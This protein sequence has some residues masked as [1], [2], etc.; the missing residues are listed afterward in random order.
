MYICA[1]TLRL[2]R[3][4]PNPNRAPCFC[5]CPPVTVTPQFLYI[6]ASWAAAAFGR[7]RFDLLGRGLSSPAASQQ[8][9]NQLRA[10]LAPS[11]G[12]SAAES[13]R[14]SVCFF[15]TALNR[16]AWG[17][18]TIP[19][20]TTVAST[21]T[22]EDAM[23]DFVFKLTQ[24][25][26]GLSG[27]G[28]SG[29]SGSSGGWSGARAENEQGEGLCFAHCSHRANKEQDDALRLA[30]VVGCKHVCREYLAVLERGSGSGDL[31]LQQCG[32]AAGAPGMVQAPNTAAQPPP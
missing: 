21:W 4:S 12:A 14:Y 10:V 31:Q 30:A 8:G 13:A 11:G 24:Q 29:S 28:S 16:T 20:A 5:T 17:G 25:L 1:P 7:D 26:N 19:E 6:P 23:R 3:P 15:A 2:R 18:A 32:S 9:F 27:G 22:G